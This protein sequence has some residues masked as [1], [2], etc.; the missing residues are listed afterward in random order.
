MRAY[1]EIV[2]FDLD[3]TLI[4]FLR[5]LTA[6]ADAWADAAAPPG[7]QDRVAQALVS[8]TLD[9]PEDPARGVR[10][11]ADRFELVCSPQRASAV[12]ERAYQE[13]I[14]PY[15]GVCGMLGDLWR[16]ETTLGLVTD[17]PRERAF[18]RL[19]AAGLE[20]LFDVI[21]TR[22]ETPHGKRGPEPFHLALSVLEGSAREA[23]MVGDWPAFD[24]RWPKTLGMEA[25]LATW[26]N[27]PDDPRTPSTGPACPVA[28]HPSEV[29][30]LLADGRRTVPP[31]RPTLRR[32][33]AAI[34]AY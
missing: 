28:C 3:N 34:T 32:G 1:P 13:A 29:P 20:R 14:E 8:G 7:Q 22:D 30:Q 12:A 2:L 5:P 11:V 18:L 21:I 6:W 27:D 19:E 9:G 33:Q 16:S 23:A 25:I 4:P 24:V 31:A 15:P 26:G 10:R 17:A